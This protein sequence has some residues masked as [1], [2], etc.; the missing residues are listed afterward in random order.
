MHLNTLFVNVQI[1]PEDEKM[2]RTVVNNKLRFLLS[3]L[4]GRS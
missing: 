3:R 4:S 1:S 2:L